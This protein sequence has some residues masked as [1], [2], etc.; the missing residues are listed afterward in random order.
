M[1]WDRSTCVLWEQR[2][3]GKKSLTGFRPRE[4]EGIIL[5]A[6]AIVLI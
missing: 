2:A 1:V 6:L 5:I 4:E 3:T